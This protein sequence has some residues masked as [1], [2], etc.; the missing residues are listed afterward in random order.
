MLADSV[1][2]TA[3]VRGPQK[4]FDPFQ[5]WPFLSYDRFVGLYVENLSDELRVKP[6]LV[7]LNDF[8]LQCK[9]KLCHVRRIDHVAPHG[10]ESGRCKFVR[11]LARRDPDEIGFLDVVLRWNAYGERFLLD[12]V[13]AE[14]DPHR[15]SYLMERIS[16]V[17]Q[18]IATSAE[19][20]LLTDTILAGA[21]QWHVEAGN[22]R[23]T[24]E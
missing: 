20:E 24:S 12:E 15:R 18:V 6:E 14:L 16:T 7:G 13:A 23:S 11:V 3:L 1:I 22:I 8:A 4:R 21:T 17:K 10:G 19:P 9:R 5:F 2:A